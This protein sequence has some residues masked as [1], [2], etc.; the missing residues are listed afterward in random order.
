MKIGD[1][2]RPRSTQHQP[3]AIGLVVKIGKNN[4]ETVQVQW[5]DRGCYTPLQFKK[6]L[7]VIA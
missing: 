1:L 2:V 5:M 7:E 3:R 4:K 6:S